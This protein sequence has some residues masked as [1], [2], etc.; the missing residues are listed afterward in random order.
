MEGYFRAVIQ[1]YFDIICQLRGV[2]YPSVEF[3]IPQDVPELVHLEIPMM[4]AKLSELKRATSVKAMIGM[5]KNFDDSESNADR[6]VAVYRETINHL[7]RLRGAP[8]FSDFVVVSGFTVAY[9]M[10]LCEI[11]KCNCVENVF[12]EAEKLM[13][14][15]YM[16]WILRNGGWVSLLEEGHHRIAEVEEDIKKMR[17]GLLYGGLALGVGIVFYTMLFMSFK[18]ALQW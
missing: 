4:L 9:C 14:E 3:S 12:S 16:A 18:R 6:I 8:F 5:C 15:I 11:G 1:R 10:H 13:S 7:I 17:M 2:N